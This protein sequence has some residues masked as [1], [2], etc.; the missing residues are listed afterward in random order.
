MRL[1]D[2]TLGGEVPARLSCYLPD[3]RIG[4]EAWLERPALLILPGSG[5]M[6]LAIR[7]GEPV[8]LRFA[9]YG[10]ATFVLHYTTVV[11]E[12]TDV[13]AGLAALEP[14][15][16][17]HYP[18]QL[19][20]AMRAMAWIRAHAA[21]LGVDGTRVFAMAFSA[22]AHVMLG[23]CERFDD[24]R[25]LTA[26][27]V[28]P[29]R[30]H[31]L[32]PEGLVLCYPMV[33]ATLARDTWQAAREGRETPEVAEWTCRGIF[34]TTEPTEADYAELD[35]TRHVR[36]ELPRTFIWQ[37]ADDN[38]VRPQETLRLV[39]E[40]M[41]TGVPC[42]AHLFEHGPHGMSLADWTIASRPGLTD[43]HVATWVDL[44]RTW[45]ARP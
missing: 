16:A 12:D 25:F 28:A 36:P 31:E 33:T 35:L 32:L 17:S 6:K 22:G 42:E 37:T 30:A 15:P 10:Y 13:S 2:V 21:E 11:A 23:M 7:E 43:P 8:A 9:G 3:A 26:A 34:G 19:L 44:V 29:E 20:Q 14:N 24:E 38:V 18:V 27:D 45:L 40:L 5:Y 39:S 4:T 41:A 1:M